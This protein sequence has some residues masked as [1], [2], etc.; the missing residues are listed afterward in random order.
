M[1]AT[2]I[3]PDAELAQIAMQGVAPTH[4]GVNALSEIEALR[5]TCPLA[6]EIALQALLQIKETV[7][8]SVE[9][10]DSEKT[11]LCFP[12]R[13]DIPRHYEGARDA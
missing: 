2:A 13:A 4:I 9:L 6:P 5:N 1:S 7:A 11:L 3:N 12:T 10:T 8:P